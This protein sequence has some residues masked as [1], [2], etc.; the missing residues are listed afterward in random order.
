MVAEREDVKNYNVMDEYQKFIHLSRYARWIEKEN[1][2]ETWEETVDRYI[3]FMC[4]EQCEGKV[5]DVTKEEIRSA[6]LNLEVMPSMRALMTAGKAAKRDNC[7]VF[8]CSYAAVDHPYVFDEALYILSCGSGF[9]FSVERQHINKLSVIAEEFFNTD[10]TLT[11]ADSRIGWATSFRELISLLYAGK[12]PKIDFSK[13]RKAGE[14]LKTFGGRSSG[15]GPLKDLFEFTIN[16]FKNAAG[17]KLTSLECH[18]IIC[19]IG[20]AIV[21]GSVRRSATISLSNVS[22]L[23]MR[24]AKSGQWWIENPQRALA[25]NSAVYTEKPDI[26]IFMDEWKALYD[27]K[28]GERGIFNRDAAIKQALKNGR[29]DVENHGESYGVNPCGEI[30]LRNNG[31]CNLSEI[32]V[33]PDD[34]KDTLMKKVRIATII[35]TLQSTCT[36]FR[37]LR[38]V[39]KKNAEEERLLGVSMTGIMDNKLMYDIS[40]KDK[41]ENLKNTL[42]ALREYSVEVN[43]EWAGILGI[44][45]S[46]AITCNKP[47]GTVSQLTNTASGIHPRFSKYY[48]RSVRNSMTDPV[49]KMLQSFN[50]PNEV[51]VMKPNDTLVFYFPIK[52]PK[53]CLTTNDIGALEQL[54][55]WKMYKNNWCEHNPSIT[56]YV[57]ENEW[58][59]VAAWVY[60]NFDEVCGIAFLPHSNHVYKQAPYQPIE[61]EEY[62]RLFNEFPKNLDYSKLSE[63]E[64]EDTTTSTR[65]MACTGDKCELV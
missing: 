12:I 41:K 26:G 36:N 32:I 20:E 24:D 56:V 35:G 19:K 9:G 43:K 28:S 44:N 53:Q 7:A 1:R 5:D 47:S 40:T 30:I 58:L 59:E 21:S 27:S 60:K 3:S 63:F 39:W 23:R 46:A 62:E 42:V 38:K 22:D 25:N 13:I 10:T 8:N 29:R 51:D 64:K 33:R 34:N 4:D 55:L 6:I 45:P 37:Y 54:E 50:V 31:F 61:K 14:K 15:P 52:S 49:S 17:R 2:R 65:E 48:I 57:K 11:V 18:D 16:I